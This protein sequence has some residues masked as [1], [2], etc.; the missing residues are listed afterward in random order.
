MW[1]YRLTGPRKLELVES[2]GPDSDS[3]MPGQVLLRTLAGGI[4][5]SDIPKFDGINFNKDQ[6]P[7]PGFPLHE[8]VGEV[9][10]ANGSD[11]A[12]GSHVVGWAAASDGLAEY[13]ITEGQRLVRYSFGLDPVPAVLIQSIACVLHALDRIDV[14]G[15]RVGVIGLGPIG[16]LFCHAARQRG[17]GKVVGVDPINRGDVTGD[18]GIDEL[19][20]K[21]SAQWLENIQLDKRVNVCIEAA[22]HQTD[23]LNHSLHATADTGTVAYFGIPD[24]PIYP[25]D[26]ERLM[27]GHL[28]LQGGVTREHR[29]S[30]VDADRYLNR[31]PEL[32][33]SLVSHVYERIEIQ[34][35]FD[36]AAEARLHRLKV[37]LDLS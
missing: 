25:I 31:H 1:A 36:V 2:P 19:V 5:G 22:G 14:K 8:I 24:T 16:L 37:L 3:L 7:P 30:L 15:Q 12:I 27:R 26:M 34:Q 6:L 13:V 4:C 10:A 35:A 32:F 23:S 17:A 11:L 33:N 28:T 21:T 9:V 29:A 18:F 20:I